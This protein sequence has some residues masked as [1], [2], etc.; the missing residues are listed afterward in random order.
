M[1]FRNEVRRTVQTDFSSPWGCVKKFVTLVT[2]CLVLLGTR[3]VGAGGLYLNEFATPS[4]G[5]AGAGSEAVAVDASTSSAMHN[6]AGMTRLDGHQLSVGAGVLVG[7]NRF[8]QD[9]NTPFSGGNGGDQ[10]G[11]A[12]IVG[13]RGVLDATDDL[14]FGM[15]LFSVSGAALD[16]DDDW[17]G[18]YSLQE[19]ELLT[20]SF[21][22]SAAYRVTDRFSVAAGFIAMFADIEYQLAAP[23]GGPGEVEIDGDDWAFGFNLGGL[24][25]VS[26]RT[27]VGVIYVSEVEPEFSGDLEIKTGGDPSFSVDETLT[28]TFPQLVRVGAYHE[29]ND[30]WALLGTVGWEDWSSF[31]SFLV[32]TP[33]GAG[34]IPTGWDD[35][36]HFSGGIHYRPTKDWLL[37]TG[38]TY[39]TSPVGASDRTADLPIDRQVR[40]AV[41]AQYQWSERIN[42]GG[43]FVYAD[44]GD[45]RIDD[46]AVLVGDY[47]DNR[48]LFFALNLGYKF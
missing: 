40:L 11:V 7:E 3:E 38:I 29:L 9:P 14:K 26:P 22:P 13:G 30:Q 16:P 19:I 17:A 33:A 2:L 25:E 1:V 41:G 31:D 12:P 47:E 28:F 10:F 4:M 34:E 39:D 45:A 18:R 37:Q 8:E 42:V 23:L 43:A 35:T 21:N 5:V 32:S 15:S 44:L 24:F 46:P 27:R 48:I 6:P 20:L 36:Y